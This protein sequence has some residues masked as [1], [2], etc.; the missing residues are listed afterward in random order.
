MTRA[1]YFRAKA[2]VVGLAFIVIG[3]FIIFSVAGE[4]LTG[5]QSR[6]WQPV[7]AVIV[8]FQKI[9]A[10]SSGSDGRWQAHDL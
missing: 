8:T 4:W 10:T 2:I 7:E 5:M 6:K 3:S 9:D 1:L